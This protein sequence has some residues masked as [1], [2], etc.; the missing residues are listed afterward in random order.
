MNAVNVKKQTWREKAGHIAGRTGVY[1]GLLLFAVWMMAPFLIIIIVSFEP[2]LQFAREGF[3]WWPDWSV[4]GYMMIFDPENEFI[5]L[6]ASGFF[7]SLWQTLIPTV[8]GL[9]V[10]GMAAYAYAKW[11][12]PGK[13]KFFSLCLVLMAVPLNAGLTSYLFY[14]AIGWTKG[15][16]AVLPIVIPGLFGSMGTI[17]LIYPYIKAVPDGIVEAARIDG[18]GFISIYWKII[19]PLSS[20]VFVAQ[21]LFGFIGGYNSYGSALMYLLGNEN[22]W[23]MQ[24]ALRQLVDGLSELGAWLNVKCAAAIFSMLPLI[25]LF[26]FSQRYFI[27][28]VSAG[29][30]KE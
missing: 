13:N 28:N 11:E 3:Q 4:E 26:C 10:S 12:F 27:E 17:F 23:T 6:L 18:M 21:F 2:D 24:L 22:L 1:V 14:N 25:V 5:T 9:F 15:G 19:I 16:A 20:P 30:V 8:G 7:N 29:G